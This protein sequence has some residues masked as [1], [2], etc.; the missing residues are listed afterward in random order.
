MAP[1]FVRIDSMLYLFELASNSD[2]V[3]TG[4]ELESHSIESGTILVLRNNH[5]F[6]DIYRTSAATIR[7]THCSICCTSSFIC[8]LR[9]FGRCNSLLEPRPVLVLRQQVRL[10]L[11]SVVVAPVL[12]VQQPQHIL[13]NTSGTSS[14]P[15]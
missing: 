15:D 9:T 8:R 13:D 2:Q 6:L 12:E 7:C 10:E 4:Y 5:I 11:H 14:T 1:R 3:L